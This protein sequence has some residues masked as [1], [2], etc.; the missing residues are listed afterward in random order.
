MRC[1][2]AEETARTCRMLIMYYEYCFYDK[3]DRMTADRRYLGHKVAP[4][5]NPNFKPATEKRRL[6]ATAIGKRCA[7]GRL[8]RDEK[9]EN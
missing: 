5:P 8:P 2:N 7:C 3:T 6:P 9:C 1:D 4:M